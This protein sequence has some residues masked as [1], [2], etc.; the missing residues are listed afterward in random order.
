VFLSRGYGVIFMH[1]AGS[2][3]PFHR[4]ITNGDLLD[5]IKVEDE[6]TITISVAGKRKE[7]LL[8]AVSLYRRAKSDESLLMVPF[9]TVFDYAHLLREISLLL[10]PLGKDAVIY[11]AAAV[12]DFYIPHDEMS[13]HKITS[14]Q[15]LQ[16]SFRRTPKLITP[17]R[18][19]WSPQAFTVTFKLE[20]DGEL[21][22]PRAR[23]ALKKYGHQ[24]VVANLLQSRHTKVTMVTEEGEEEKDLEERGE[25]E[26]E[27][28]IVDEIISKHSDYT[29]S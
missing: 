9:I 1:R 22:V 10:N 3:R 23:E 8:E 4:H 18:N 7:K 19:S 2:L 20:T 6:G 15:S 25:R 16:L 17:L 5:C 11:L 14:S 27:Q 12:S 21:L 28:L 24:V 29:S 26:I 13:Q